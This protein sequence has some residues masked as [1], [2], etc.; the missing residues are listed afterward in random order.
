MRWR[1]ANARYR[2]LICY[3]IGDSRGQFPARQG[4]VIPM[5]RPSFLRTG[6]A[7]PALCLSCPALAEGPDAP[8]APQ[9]YHDQQPDIVVTAIIPRRQGDILS[10]T[11]VV[12]G[13]ELTRALRPTIGDTLAHQPG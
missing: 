7:I 8:A 5:P 10:G 1:V 4:H 6:C 13:E 11:S 9:F 2:V 3:N 12:S